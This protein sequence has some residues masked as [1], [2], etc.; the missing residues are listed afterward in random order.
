MI[1]AKCGS[2]VIAWGWRNRISQSIT[3]AKSV[4]LRTT[5]WSS[6]RT[7]GNLGT[8][9]NLQRDCQLNRELRFFSW[10]NRVRRSYSSDGRFAT[11][12]TVTEKKPP[13]RRMT[14]NS[15]E[16]LMSLEDV[17]AARN[18]LEFGA[19]TSSPPSSPKAAADEE[20]KSEDKDKD[21]PPSSDKEEKKKSSS[22]DA[23]DMTGSNKE[24]GGFALYIFYSS[25]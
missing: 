15:R 14:F 8:G 21:S 2:I 19:Y 10:N 5:L 20:S 13:K 25:Y 17:L 9:E 3:T 12:T 7:E 11:S 24:D 18:A 16:A 23:N 4:S 6:L 22:S 1:N